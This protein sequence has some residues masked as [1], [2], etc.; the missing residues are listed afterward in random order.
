VTQESINGRPRGFSSVE[1]H[2]LLARMATLFSPT[3]PPPVDRAE[4]RNAGAIVRVV[5]GFPVICRAVAEVSRADRAALQQGAMHS[6]EEVTQLY[7]SGRT[8]GAERVESRLPSVMWRQ[9]D[10]SQS[11]QQLAA[12]AGSPVCR[13]GDLIA[14]QD[15]NDRA[16][17]IGVVRR[18]QRNKTE[19]M[20]YGVEVM[21]RKL[22]RVMLQ[23]RDPVIDIFSADMHGKQRPFYGLYLPSLPENRLP[24]RRSLILPEARYKEGGDLNLITGTHRYVIRLDTLIE[25]ETGWVWASFNAVDKF[26]A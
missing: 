26:D 13:L 9:I 17:T 15:V 1:Q 21:A 5:G 12:P 11:G 10:L 2:Y 16:W 22:I 23:E 18:V 7:L 6:Y 3:P 19:E 24:G 14:T 25:K 4:R 20:H 8:T